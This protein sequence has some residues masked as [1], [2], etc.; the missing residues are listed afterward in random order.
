MVLTGASNAQRILDL[1]VR[2]S[3]LDDDEISTILNIT[4]RQQVNQI[5]RRLER[6]GTVRREYGPRGKIVNIPLRRAGDP[7]I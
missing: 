5:C 3:A 2:R 7:H 6:E 4:P 1:L